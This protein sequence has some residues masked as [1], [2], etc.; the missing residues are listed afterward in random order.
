MSDETSNVAVLTEAY[1]RWS[2]SRGGSVDHWMSICDEKIA[3]GS[4]IQGAA[5]K[6]AYMT[7]YN[8]RPSSAAISKGLP[9]T[10]R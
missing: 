10:G 3:F 6:V 2:D 5:P 7:E 1:R 4:L 9:A 8:A